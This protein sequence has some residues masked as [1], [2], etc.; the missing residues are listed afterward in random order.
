MVLAILASDEDTMSI[1]T[2]PRPPRAD[3]HSDA[4][5]PEALIEEARHR[6]RRR[7]R[8]YTAAALVAAAAGLLGFYGFNHGGATRPQGHENGPVGGA[9]VGA[10]GDIASWRLAAGLPGGDIDELVVDPQHARV[11]FASSGARVFK[12][13]NGGRTWRPQELSRSRVD[14]LAMAPGDP[15]TLYVGTARGVF[16][17]TDGGASWEATSAGLLP[18]KETAERRQHRLAEG[19]VYALVVDRRDPDIVY[20]GTYVTGVFKTTNGG[21]SWR[22]VGLGSVNTLA[23]DPRDP[24]TIYAGAVGAAA[25]RGS[26]YDWSGVFKSSNGG[27]NWQPLGLKGTNVSALVLDPQHP[28]TIY[29]STDRKGLVKSTDGGASWHAAGLQGVDALMFDPEHPR[30]LYAGTDEKGV[31]K[32]TDGGRTWRPLGLGRDAELLALHPGNPAKL[33]AGSVGRILTR[34]DAGRSWR[35]TGRGP[36]TASISAFAVDARTGIAYAGI[37]GGIARRTGGGWRTVNM[38][39]PLVTGD[40]ATPQTVRALAVDPRDPDVVYAGVDDPVSLLKSTDGGRSWRPL[41]VPWKPWIPDRGN[42]TF[43]AL[44]V[45]PQNPKAVYAYVENFADNGSPVWFKSTDGGATWE[46]AHDAFFSVADGADEY[47]SV[48]AFDPLD[49]NTRYAYG[50]GAALFKSTDGGASWRR[51]GYPF[52][53]ASLN[54]ENLAIDPREPATLYAAAGEQDESGEG[55][56]KSTDAGSSWRAVGLKGHNVWALAIDP[57]QRRT[58]YAGTESGLFRSTNG[59]RSWSRFSRGLPRDGIE[60]VAVDPVGGILYA[61]LTGGGI[62]ELRL[63]R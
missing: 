18:A 3:D 50:S 63:P 29:A 16:K 13:G 27:A 40:V 61:V 1:L 49:P 24:E 35:A 25:G 39:T 15:N 7:R 58:V 8:G 6:A 45:D 30:T 48:L 2:R 43:S 32:S 57:Q 11:M 26:I 46:D 52:I 12:S 19:Y 22:S 42:A 38:H 56:F 28:E 4:A 59:G 44:A 51:A 37:G 55:I 53:P 9:G 21:A 10:S 5:A 14:E 31:F 36:G 47:P 60:S 17:T 54:V 34:L 62:Y 23:L 33:Y 41:R 20:A